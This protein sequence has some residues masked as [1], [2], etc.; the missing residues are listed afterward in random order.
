MRSL[1]AVLGLGLLIAAPGF[2]EETPYR[3][4]PGDEIAISV[5]PRTEYSVSGPVSPDGLVYLKNVGPIR[6]AGLTLTE[7]SE[8][9]REALE[10]I[11]KRPRVSASLVRLAPQAQRVTVTGAVLKAGPVDLEPNLRLRKAI[12]LAGGPRLEADLSR[13]VVVRRDLTRAVVDLSSDQGPAD[14]NRNPFLRD[15]DSVEVP[16]RPR[17]RVTVVGGV[18]RPGAVE[19]LDALALRKAL[20]LAG[21]TLAEGDLRRVVVTRRD[22]TRSVLDLS[23]GSGAAGETLL[24]DGDSVEVPLLFRAGYVSASGE[25]AKSGPYPLQPGMT[26]EDL[27]VAA[28]RLTTV[29]DVDRI[30][31]RRVG[32]GRQVI[33]LP[34]QQRKGADGKV[35]LQPGDELYVPR[36]ENTVILVGAIPNPGAR[37]IKPGQTLKGFFTEGQVETL[38]ALDDARVD[39]RR[40]QVIRR[41]SDTKSVDLKAVIKSGKRHRD[42]LAL[43]SG[44][45]LFLPAREGPKRSFLDYLRSAPYIGGLVNLFTP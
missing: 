5:L 11:L 33:S 41:G 18:A 20:E 17:V 40:L 39:L 23:P 19:S 3:L 8:R 29:A 13:V 35:L 27:I 4:Q 14:P 7:L 36:Q 6:A 15:G 42:D 43:Q 34:E 21:G 9:S 2:G 25:L 28:G 12:D 45:I 37:A 31:L 10:K 24:Q 22:L 30:E 16:E 44:D 32:G 26:L 1:A 38:H